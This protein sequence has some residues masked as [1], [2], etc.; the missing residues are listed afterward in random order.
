MSKKLINLSKDMQ[1]VYSMYCMSTD[2]SVS[3]DSVIL[4]Y[5]NRKKLDEFLTES[6]YKEE[7]LKHGLKPI[8]RIL[9]YGASGTGKTY[10]TTALANYLGYELLA[11]DISNALAAGVASKALSDVFALANEIEDAIIFLD[12]CDAICWARDDK[13]NDDTGEIRRANN[14]LFQLLDRL[15]PRCLFVS[16]TNLYRNLDPAFV[17]RFNVKMEFDRPSSESIDPA[18]KK[19]LHPDFT[20]EKNMKQE[21][22]DIVLKQVDDYDRLSYHAIRDWVERVEKQA[23]I[24]NSKIIREASI[25]WYLEQELRIQVKQNDKGE[26]Y[27]HQ[28][29]KGQYS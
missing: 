4:S 11:I 3:L 18:I 14:T 24:D 25:Y 12:E 23:I 5:K 28:F 8:N 15:N 10:L 17:R 20:Y 2:T 26:Y 27:L 16:A 29:A 6:K 22:K 9:M 13:D 7:F 19:F 21:V 1:D